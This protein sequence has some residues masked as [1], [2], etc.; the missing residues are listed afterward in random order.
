[1]D[2]QMPRMGGLEA[3]RR[4][5]ARESANPALPRT[6]I[7]AITAAALPAEEAAGLEAGVDG[8]LT[9]PINKVQLQDLL[10]RIAERATVSA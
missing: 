10:A 2:M 9:K 4:I 5:R 1:M 3:T 8:Y 7:Y 6:P